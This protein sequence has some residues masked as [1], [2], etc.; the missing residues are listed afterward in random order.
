MII[1]TTMEV[2]GYKVI[3][4]RGMVRGVIVRSPTIMQGWMSGLKNLVGG[5]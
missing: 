1:S 3:E 5:K 4:Y 2:D